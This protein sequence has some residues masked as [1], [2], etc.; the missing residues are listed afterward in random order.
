MPELKAA[1]RMGN[2][3]QHL[4]VSIGWHVCVGCRST[5]PVVEHVCIGI[6]GIIEDPWGYSSCL[7]LSTLEKANT[8]RRLVLRR[9]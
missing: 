8:V 4:H 6:V 9:V 2:L 7:F 5:A 1:M 3:N